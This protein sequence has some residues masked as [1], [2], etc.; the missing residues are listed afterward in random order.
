L[1]KKTVAL[2]TASATSIVL[3]RILLEIRHSAVPLYIRYEQGVENPKDR[4][5]AILTIGDLALMKAPSPDYPYRYDLG[6]LWREFTGLPFVFALWQV[7]SK[8]P[9]HKELSRL[10]DIL[11]E[12][13]A[14]GLS[15][16]PEL[17][18]ESADRCGIP[19]PALLEY[20][21][22]FSYGFGEEERKGLMAYYQYA[23]ELGA[24]KPVKDLRIWAKG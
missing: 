4:A 20:W 23:A 1:N 22:L 9:V 11:M 24:I 17:A 16:L 12:S 13:R 15:H 2:T 6:E 18:G 3:L 21:D 8:K 19:E 10:Y 14:Y 7:N 5:D